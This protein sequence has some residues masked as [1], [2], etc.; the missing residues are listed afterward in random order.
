MWKKY[1]IINI[2]SSAAIFLSIELDFLQ[3]YQSSV[4]QLKINYIKFIQK[5]KNF[6]LNKHLVKQSLFINQKHYKIIT[7]QTECSKVKT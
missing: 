5:N 7:Q 6:R 1:A 2:F 3:L 4:K